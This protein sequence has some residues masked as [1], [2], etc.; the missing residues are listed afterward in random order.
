MKFLLKLAIFGWLF[1]SQFVSPANCQEAI[2]W[3][4]E[5]KNSFPNAPIKI[6]DREIMGKSF[7]GYGMAGD[8][9]LEDL[10]FIVKN[11]SAKNIKRIEILLMIPQQGG[12]EANY[13][14]L[15]L[16][17]HRQA[18]K[19]ENGGTISAAAATSSM[20]KPGE[21]MKLTTYK[22]NALSMLKS[23]KEKGVFDIRNVDLWLMEVRFE[24]GT[25]KVGGSDAVEDADENLRIV[26]PSDKPQ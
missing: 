23:A 13:G 9:W 12:M 22:P 19:D 4:H 10:T 17:D 26:K 8:D 3:I 18:Q 24:D 14:F 7:S 20:L 21:T 5:S 6:V 11:D 16:F 2:R 25:G 1:L 15:Y